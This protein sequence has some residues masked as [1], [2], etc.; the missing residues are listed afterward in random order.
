LFGGRLA[1]RRG[2]F[3][4]GAACLPEAGAL[5]GDRHSVIHRDNPAV[6]SG[7]SVVRFGD[8]IDSSPSPAF[9]HFAIRAHFLGRF[10]G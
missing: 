9:A 3:S 10:E 2:D 4:G 6:D 8:G 7:L 5:S 1:F